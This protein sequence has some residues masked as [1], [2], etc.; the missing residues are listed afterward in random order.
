MEK[1]ENEV[2]VENNLE[3][4][5]TTTEVKTIEEFKK[6]IKSCRHVKIY[7]ETLGYYHHV[8]IGKVDDKECQ[9]YHYQCQW[10]EYVYGHY[11]A[12][13]TKESLKFSGTN[14]N[15]EDIFDFKNSRV[16]IVSRNE[17][18]KENSETETETDTFIEK[19]ESRVGETKY[20]ICFNNCECYVNWI[21][22]DNNN[23]LELLH[24]SISK[25][26]L[27]G[28][29]DATLTDGSLRPLKHGTPSV[30]TA[31][32]NRYL[33]FFQTKSSPKTT[34]YFFSKQPWSKLIKLQMPGIC[35]VTAP[36]LAKSVSEPISNE[37]ANS[38]APSFA[39]ATSKSISYEEGKSGAPTIAKSVSKSM[40]NEIEKSAAPSVPKATSKSISNEEAKSTTSSI[41][42]SV[43]KSISKKLPKRGTPSVAKSASKSISNETFKS[44][45]PTVTKSASESISNEAT[46]SAAPSV[47]KAVSKSISSEAIKSAAPSVAKA[48][49]ESISNEVAKSTAPTVTKSA[50]ESISNEAT[51]SAAPSVAKAVSKSISSE[52][53]KSAAP[54]VAKAASESI[55]NEVAK[56]AVAKPAQKEIVKTMHESITSGKGFNTSTGRAAENATKSAR[57]PS[58]W[59]TKSA[60]IT[61]IVFESVFLGKKIYDIMTE[62]D[63][64]CGKEHRKRI[65]AME[66]FSSVVGVP[67]GLY[68]SVVGQ[69][70]IPV[71]LLGA[72]VGGIIGGM[73]GNAVGG[74]IGVGVFSIFK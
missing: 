59:I 50:S 62:V 51:K 73:I 16:E 72:V 8:F 43:S 57:K 20:L 44:A 25:Q 64:E 38:A 10:K 65:L 53:T 45:A 41:A 19:A 40:S 2:K 34:T 6:K 23:S 52:A 66:T 32:I 1:R 35:F 7:R 15:V 3:R 48:A 36:S 61:T 9:I 42:K 31:T 39:K 17:Y 69:A 58:P 63:M 14:Q 56:K 26:T 30:I 74:A 13:I 60:V 55:S 37:I 18:P 21:F 22:S 47:A 5:E 12:K 68:G 11:P 54:S 33:Y 27:A 70:L 4:G 24:S 46:K 49:S 29:I 71:P 67:A 28:A